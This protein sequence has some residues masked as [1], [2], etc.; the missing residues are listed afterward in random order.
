MTKQQLFKLL[1]RRIEVSRF[2]AHVR[3]DLLKRLDKLHNQVKNRVYDVDLDNIG[4]RELN[5]LIK[6]IEQLSSERHAELTVLMTAYSAE[7]IDDEADFIRREMDWQA[8]DKTPDFVPLVLGATISEWLSKQARDYAHSVKM[9]VR[10]GGTLDR[11]PRWLGNQTKSFTVTWANATSQQTQRKLAEKSKGFSE[12]QHN[13]LL[14]SKTSDM[15][16]VR[17]LKRWT[18]DKEPIDHD[19]KYEEPPLHRH[20]RSFMT[21]EFDFYDSSEIDGVTADEWLDSMSEKEQNR[22]LGVGKAAMYR[23]GDITLRDLLD[24]SGRPKT[25]KSYKQSHPE[26][27]MRMLQDKPLTKQALK[28][29]I[30][31]DE[32]TKAL[33]NIMGEKYHRQV[34][35]ELSNKRIKDKT[36]AYGLTQSEAVAIRHYTSNGYDSI[37]AYLR[38]ELRD[39]DN[40]KSVAQAIRQG[41]DKL[42]NYEGMAVRRVDL[43]DNILKNHQ[44][45]GIVTYEAF[46]SATFGKADVFADKLHRLV[47]HSKTAKRIDW[48]AYLQKEEKEVLFTSP[49]KFY[50]TEKVKV[51]DEWHIE[52]FEL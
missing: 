12:Y 29:K 44:T 22:T 8:P 47:I 19:L 1:K 21:F 7:L 52:M 48:L 5:R 16:I 43:P 20:C 28:A 46:T 17:H 6:E 23:R 14:D 4:K 39:D 42:P 40:L 32:A 13:S 51:G 3:R 15:C 2:E 36:K 10:T 33:Q 30:S 45:G 18:A 38:G 11:L 37:N 34:V 35:G 9:A 24:Q 41:L 27:Y 26:A 50:I 25:L 49:T 31:D